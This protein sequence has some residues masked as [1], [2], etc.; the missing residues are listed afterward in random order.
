[1]AL[2]VKADPIALDIE[3]MLNESLS[4]KA[5]AEF[6]RE[7]IEDVKQYDAR[8]LGRVPK[9]T[10]VV[11]GR[12]GASLE[13][14]KPNGVIVATFDVS[15]VDALAWIHQQLRAHSPVSHGYDPD[16]NV[17]YLDSHKLFADGQEVSIEGPFP[18]ARRFVFVNTTPYAKKIERGASSQ[19]PDGVY[20]AV[21]ILAQPRFPDMDIQ[22]EYHS[23]GAYSLMPAIVVSPRSS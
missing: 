6:A 12:N 2:T 8:I 17:E 16:P 21:A 7:Q 10:V 9:V 19:A 22:F 5:K 4:P 13:S 23:G 3:L 14:V 15:N 11:D 20:Q 18:P 1:M